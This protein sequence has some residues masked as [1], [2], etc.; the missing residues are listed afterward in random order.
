MRTKRPPL[1]RVNADDFE[2]EVGGAVYLN[3]EGKRKVLT[4]WQE[5]KRSEIVH[6]YLGEKIMTGLIP[7]VQSMLLAKYIR[8]EI[9]EYPNYIVKG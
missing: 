4:K 6:P 9:E 7:Y 8:G 5:R 3:K 2:A 1:D